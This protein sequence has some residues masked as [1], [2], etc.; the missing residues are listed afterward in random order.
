LRPE[1]LLPE[2]RA[3]I[4][5]EPV[6]EVAVERGGGVLAFPVQPFIL[7]L[8]DGKGGVVSPQRLGNRGQGGLN[9]GSP[10]GTAGLVR[11]CTASSAGTKPGPFGVDG[12]AEGE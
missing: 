1:T 6:K 8:A 9:T 2:P 4:A 5:D 11:N 12:A 10:P 7:R 3:E